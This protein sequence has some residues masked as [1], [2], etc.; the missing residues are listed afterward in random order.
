MKNIDQAAGASAV[1][2]SGILVI[3]NVRNEQ[4]S[5]PTQNALVIEP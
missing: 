5:V 3:E 2:E 4:R 1:A